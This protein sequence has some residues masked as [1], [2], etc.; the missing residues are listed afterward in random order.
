MTDIRDTH[1]HLEGGDLG[2]KIRLDAVAHDRNTYSEIGE[3]V[4]QQNS[5][6]APRIW[7][8]TY[9]HDMDLAGPAICVSYVGIDTADGHAITEFFDPQTLMTYYS[10]K[11]TQ[12]AMLR[13]QVVLD[14]Q[15]D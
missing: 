14:G 9:A 11:T 5:A 3:R 6:R 15:G 2:I 4:A 13:D 10:L 8:W 12:L 1:E 7:V